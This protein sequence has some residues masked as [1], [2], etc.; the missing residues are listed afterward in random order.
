[1][2]GGAVRDTM[3]FSVLDE[4]WPEVEALLQEKLAALAG[5]K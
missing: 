3:V 5:E 4:E 1:M 2:P